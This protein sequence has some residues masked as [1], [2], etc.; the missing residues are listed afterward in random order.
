MPPEV[1]ILIVTWNSRD[2]VLACLKT[3]HGLPDT[4]SREIVVVDN[5]SAD[6]T[7]EAIRA[8]WPDVHVVASPTNLGFGAANNLGYRLASGRNI[9]ILNPD[10]RL[11]PG[12]LGEMVAALRDPAIG[13]VGAKH[14][15]TD[16][17]LQWSMDDHPTVLSETIHYTDVHR[18]GLLRP[19]L[20][21]RYPRWSAHNTERDVA[22][23]NGACMM[24]TRTVMDTVR[25][26]DEYFFLFAEELDLCRRI[27]NAGWRV[28]FLPQ[29]GVIHDLGGSFDPGDGRRLVLLHQGSF[30]YARRHFSP[31]Q[32]GALHVFLRANALVRFATLLGVTA[33]EW[34]L[35]RPLMSELF[36]RLL[37]QHEDALPRSEAIRMW[38][39]VATV[40]T[41]ADIQPR[42]PRR[43]GPVG[44]DAAV[45]PHP[46]SGPT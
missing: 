15:N 25:G 17:T 37:V 19:W 43:V 40:R 16:M 34:V 4:V 45:R 1:S 5:A 28:R 7:V 22:W 30:R 23:V 14:Y 29:A 38:W 21:R 20:H 24:I 12:A 31:A 13:C 33:A 11:L 41:N 6:H 3:I 36:L 44:G 32:R 9:L 10:T 2:R 35:R 27:W 26:F 18:L 39:A 46:H 8:A 42:T